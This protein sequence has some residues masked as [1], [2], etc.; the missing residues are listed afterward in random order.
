MRSFPLFKELEAERDKVN[1]EFH[2]AT[3]PQLIEIK[4]I[5]FYAARS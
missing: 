4:G 1:A 5:W 2:K 3:K